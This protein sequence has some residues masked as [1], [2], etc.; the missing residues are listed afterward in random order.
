MTRQYIGAR[1]VPIIDGEYNSEKVYEPLTIVT[2]NG[3]SYTSKKSVPA[4]TLPTNTEYWALTGNYNAQVEAYR[5]E[6]ADCITSVESVT[7]KVKY[8]T[9]EM[10]GAKGDGV[11]D[12]TLAFKRFVN[13]LVNLSDG[14]A[15]VGYGYG[16]Y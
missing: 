1:Y 7:K 10:F 12:D 11:T 15:S 4:G 16:D 9:P 8:L 14:G 3:S 2:Y 6:V 5:Q 13:E